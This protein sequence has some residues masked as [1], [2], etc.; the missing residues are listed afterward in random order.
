[1]KDRTLH[2][3]VFPK[4]VF[5]TDEASVVRPAPGSKFV[6]PQGTRAIKDRYPAEP[7]QC[8]CL[9]PAASGRAYR[10]LALS[11]GFLEVVAGPLVRSSCRAE[12][13]LERNNAGL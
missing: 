3:T 4:R 10:E 7:A 6:S 11:K 5:M 9:M 2:E 12:R 8:G 13:V 1:V